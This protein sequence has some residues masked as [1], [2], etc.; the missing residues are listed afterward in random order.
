[1]TTAPGVVA[2]STVTIEI[3]FT[4]T[5]DLRFLSIPLFTG[6]DGTELAIE[7]LVC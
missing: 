4:N 2:L 7:F 6:C 5:A 3:Y 1:M